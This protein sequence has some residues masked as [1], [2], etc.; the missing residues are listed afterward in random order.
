MSRPWDSYE[1]LYEEYEKKRRST[2]SIAEEHGTYPNT[3]RRCLKKYGFTI[4]DKS[5]AQ[6]N[7]IEIHGSPMLGRERSR[8]EK[9]RISQG[10][11]EYWST[12]DEP[13]KDQIKKKMAETA[14]KQWETLSDHERKESIYRMHLASKS[15]M[16]MGSK[17]ENLV[18]DMLVQSGY[19][20]FQRTTDYTPGNRFEIDIAIPDLRI[21]I[22]WDG[23]TH[24]LPIY[25]QEHLDKVMEK[26]EIKNKILIGNGW[27][28]LRCRDHSTAHSKAFCR[29]AVDTIVETIRKI[30]ENNTP[31]S[32][33]YLDIK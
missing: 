27:R 8:E 31:P 24:F 18:A 22:E 30:Q 32:V 9:E 15:R 13:E 11:Q 2:K 17:N 29:R 1:Y 23:A 4:R 5:E 33:T 28:V 3:I 12:L 20:I 14:K 26:D 6:K 7:F 16:Y 19:R 21:A 10:L 25:G